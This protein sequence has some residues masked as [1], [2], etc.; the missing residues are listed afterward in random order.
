MPAAAAR[1]DHLSPDQSR[2]EITRI[3]AVG[4]LRLRAIRQSA[5]QSTEPATEITEDSSPPRLE[6][7]TKTVLSVLSGLTVPRVPETRSRT[8]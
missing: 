2:T 5:G 8:C 4:F 7:S 3:L 1:P 6:V